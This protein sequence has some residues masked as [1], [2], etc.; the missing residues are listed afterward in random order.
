MRAGKRS[1][2]F[3]PAAATLKADATE[4]R[5]II[6][7]FLDQMVINHNNNNDDFELPWVEIPSEFRNPELI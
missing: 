1:K 7:I 2:R 4:M 3:G 6:A 5:Q